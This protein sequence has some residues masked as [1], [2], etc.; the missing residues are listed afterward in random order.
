M[1]FSI[2]QSA[3]TTT[4]MAEIALANSQGESEIDN[5]EQQQEVVDPEISM[6]PPQEGVLK[7]DGKQYIFTLQDKTPLPE[8]Y[9]NTLSHKTLAKEKKNSLA[10]ESKEESKNEDILKSKEFKKIDSPSREKISDSSSAKSETK[11]NQTALST[12]QK[13]PPPR[14]A[15]R[16]EHF[17]SRLYMN[18]KQRVEKESCRKDQARSEKGSEGKKSDVKKADLRH[19]PQELNQRQAD[20]SKNDQERN[21]EKE[22]KEEEEGFSEQQHRGE[23]EDDRSHEQKRTKKIGKVSEKFVQEFTS[24]GLEESILSQ[25]FKMRVSQFDVLILF[26]EIMKL[27][28]R[29]REQERIGRQVEREMQIKHMQLVVENYKKQ[30]SDLRNASL[31]A[32]IMG[33]GAGLLPIV[34]FLKGDWILDKFGSVPFLK[35]FQNQD[36]S[37]VFRYFS[38]ALGS[39]SEMQKS[40]GE[41]QRTFAESD[42]SYDQHMSDLFRTDWEEST[43]SMEEIKDSWKGIENFLYQYLQM[44]HDA[45]RQLY[46]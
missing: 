1:G 25:I 41:V 3:Q 27:D 32:G 30:A 24:Y 12:L 19:P 21:Q 8:T 18:T 11:A 42:R 9:A 10:K 6:Q 13:F 28:I 23:E 36:P 45:V 37:K 16:G 35:N 31:I 39:G 15:L 22:R 34:G 38:Q 46:N 44:N 33:I 26:M 29:G 14:H 2:G 40:L 43:R 4:I 7:G 5:L 20:R 17:L